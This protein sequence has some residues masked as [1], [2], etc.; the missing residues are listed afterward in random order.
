MKIIAQG[1]L[2]EED[3]E[4]LQGALMEGKTDEL[5]NKLEQFGINHNLEGLRRDLE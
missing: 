3:E 1:K 5:L 4:A 2:E